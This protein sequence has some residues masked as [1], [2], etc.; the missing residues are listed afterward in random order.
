MDF[1]NYKELLLVKLI[2]SF[3][4]PVA[5]VPS[6]SLCAARATAAAAAPTWWGCRDL[7]FRT[8]MVMAPT[9]SFGFRATGK[10]NICLIRYVGMV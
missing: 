6:S 2:K 7:G 10:C 9:S 8:A 5:A 1:S 3:P 4:R